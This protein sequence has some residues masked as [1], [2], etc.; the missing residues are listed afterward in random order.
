MRIRL[1]LIIAL[2]STFSLVAQRTGVSGVVVDAESG[3]PVSGASVILENQN[4]LVITGPAGDFL[5]SN[6]SPGDDKLSIVS[7]GYQDWSQN[8]MIIANVVDNLGTIKLGPDNFSVSSNSNALLPRKLDACFKAYPLRHG[9]HT[10]RP[11]VPGRR[12]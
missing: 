4:I 8:V 6:A 3:F 7:Y 2:L 9:D 5:I 12:T 11:R 1:F 10:W